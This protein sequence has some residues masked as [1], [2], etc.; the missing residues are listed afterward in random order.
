MLIVRI[1]LSKINF[2]SFHRLQTTKIYSIRD[3]VIGQQFM[4]VRC[5]VI[6]MRSR[7]DQKWLEI[8]GNQYY[9]LERKFKYVMGYV[10]EDIIAMNTI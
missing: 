3:H 7:A 6:Y 4:P 1:N 9:S 5:Y 2:H 8:T 10:Y